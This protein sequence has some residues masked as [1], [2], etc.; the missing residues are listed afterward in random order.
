MEHALNYTLELRDHYH[1]P[2]GD[3]EETLDRLNEN[4]RL[5]I[6]ELGGDEMVAKNN[7]KEL[8][9]PEENYDSNEYPAYNALCRGEAIEVRYYNSPPNPLLPYSTHK[10]LN[11][12]N[13]IP[14][15]TRL[16]AVHFTNKNSSIR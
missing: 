7:V 8:V 6:E 16:N 2:E 12:N 9:K 4:V 3:N 14:Q 15:L 10:G 1:T 11:V 5:Y 13:T